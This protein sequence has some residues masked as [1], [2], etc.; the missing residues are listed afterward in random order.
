MR[1]PGL[2]RK[3]SGL[4]PFPGITALPTP[5]RIDKSLSSHTLPRGNLND[6]LDQKTLVTC[7]LNLVINSSSSRL[8]AA[9]R[10]QRIASQKITESTTTA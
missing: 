6:Q 7:Q 2:R 5:G 1:A 4:D 9:N 8:E 3:V 10:N